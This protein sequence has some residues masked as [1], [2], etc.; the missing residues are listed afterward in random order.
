MKRDPFLN[1][2]FI[3]LDRLSAWL[4]L[5]AVFSALLWSLVWQTGLG[6]SGQEAFRQFIR[7]VTGHAD[8]PGLVISLL[9][10]S[11]AVFLVTLLSVWSFN[12]WN[13]TGK[14]HKEH[15]RGTRL[16]DDQ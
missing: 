7:F 1:R 6:F 3:I 5:V 10:L 13:R 15:L 9:V 14:L 16:G 8:R 4:W 2:I 12:R 11:D